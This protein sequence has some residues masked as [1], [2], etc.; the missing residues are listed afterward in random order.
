VAEAE[1]LRRA[2]EVRR[3]R[4][5]KRRD[6]LF[7][8]A[9]RYRQYQ[10]LV[11]LRDHL[12]PNVFDRAEPIDRMTKVLGSLVVEMASRFERESLNEEIVKLVLIAD[13]DIL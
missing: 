2:E 6:F 10:A 11:A 12:T 4:H 8:A 3:K 7:K 5:N 13:D 1:N 9:R